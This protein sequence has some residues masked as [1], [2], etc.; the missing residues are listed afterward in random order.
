MAK[1]RKKPI[2]IEAVKF[3]DT[4]ESISAISEL[5]HGKLIR[6]DYRQNPVVMYIPTLEGVMAA[7]VGD[8]IIRGIK[9]ELYPC[10]PDIFEKTYER[11]NESNGGI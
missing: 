5:S 7:Q 10:K 2:E 11:V 3:E 1:Y 6:V 8:Y 4:T 9:G